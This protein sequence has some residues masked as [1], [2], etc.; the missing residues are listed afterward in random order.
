MSR[1]RGE[2]ERRTSIFEG[3]YRAWS[4]LGRLQ[5]S[6]K[7]HP[8]PLHLLDQIISS[9]PAEEGGTYDARFDPSGGVSTSQ[10]LKVTYRHE[11]LPRKGLSHPYIR[12]IL[13]DWQGPDATPKELNNGLTIFRN[14]WQH[15]RNGESKTA[16]KELGTEPMKLLI[17]EKML[18]YFELG[19]H[20]IFEQGEQ[21]PKALWNQFSKEEKSRRNMEEKKRRV[22][23]NQKELKRKWSTEIDSTRNN[24]HDD[25]GAIDKKE[26]VDSASGNKRQN[27]N[28]GLHH[29]HD[30]NSSCCD[31][32]AADTMD[33][34][35][36]GT[37][38]SFATT[39]R[40]NVDN[41]NM[42]V[43]ERN[44]QDLGIAPSKVSPR[45]HE[46]P[47]IPFMVTIGQSTIKPQCPRRVSPPTSQLSD[48]TYRQ[49]SAIDVVSDDDSDNSDCKSPVIFISPNG[50]I[51]IALSILNGIKCKSCINMIETALVGPNNGDSS[52]PKIDGLLD[53]IASKTYSS[54]ILKITKSSNARFVASRAEQALSEVGYDAKVKEMNVIDHGGL[55]VDLSV[56]CTAFDV[57][58]ATKEEDVMDWSLQCV[59]Q[60]HDDCERHGPQNMRLFDAFARQEIQINGFV[61][62][63]GRRHGYSCSCGPKCRCAGCCEHN[64]FTPSIPT[65]QHST[66]KVLTHEVTSIPKPTMNKNHFEDK[67]SGGCCTSATTVENPRQMMMSSAYHKELLRQSTTLDPFIHLHHNAM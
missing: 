54:V 28:D 61:G 16:L 41:R 51:Q 39:D 48:P 15:R 21:P 40:T 2:F 36:A 12:Q 67:V 43:L 9:L 53:A 65:L 47:D 63:C 26:E 30:M 46:S 3:S 23:E 37:R 25:G 58:A 19:F 32:R 14:W 66:A 33:G 62:G 10:P 29:H 44:Y 11:Q 7:K 27:L 13:I 34:Y 60:E 22:V 57:V 17:K 31:I 55:P 49:Y 4:H 52:L 59:C 45:P 8:S 35:P 18:A 42:G 5:P 56:L 64:N 24:N 38:T 1:K 50:D 6:D 20:F